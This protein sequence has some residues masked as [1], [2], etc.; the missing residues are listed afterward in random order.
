MFGAGTACVVSPISHIHFLNQFL[1]IPTMEQPSP[2]YDMI[3]KSLLNIQ[4]GYVPNHPW[5][6]KVE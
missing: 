5:I 4:Y 1:H 2:I 3:L 6:I